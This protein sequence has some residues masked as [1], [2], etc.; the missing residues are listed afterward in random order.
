VSPLCNSQYR[1]DLAGETALVYLG[2][3]YKSD[4][5]QRACIFLTGAGGH[6]LTVQG[7]TFRHLPQEL[8]DMGITVISVDCG[9]NAGTS[10]AYAWGNDIAASRIETARTATLPALGLKNDKM[11][12]LGGSGGFCNACQYARQFPARVAALAGHV[13]LVG[14]DALHDANL[15][16]YAAAIETQYGGLAAYDAAVP[17]HDPTAYG[18]AVLQVGAYPI[19]G[20]WSS[21][22]ALILPS[23][24][25]AFKAAVPKT[26]HVDIGAQGHSVPVAY[27]DDTADFILA[28]L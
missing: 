18:A 12:L 2:R 7:S 19:K 25:T 14:L 13:G 1:S 4:L 15:G 5:T 23:T 24:V 3:G 11:V 17:T 6:A 8:A 20:W 10:S 9:N 16:G 26:E 22:D 21:D 28:N 27:D